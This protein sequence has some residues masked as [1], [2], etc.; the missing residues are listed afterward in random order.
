MV[1]RV[2]KV[3]GGLLGVALL[4]GAGFYGW[5][6]STTNQMRAQVYDVHTVDLP[7]PYPLTESEIADL[8]GRKAAEAVAS[9]TPADGVALASMATADPAQAVDPLAGVDLNAIALENAV[10]RGKHLVEARYGCQICHG[11]DFSGGTMVDSPVLGTLKG[12]NLTGGV[13]SPVVDFKSSD[14]ERLVRH[15]VRPDGTPVAMPSKDYAAMSD[16][17]LSDI[18]AYIKSQPKVDNAVPLP[19]FG[20]LF[21]VLTALGKIR[22]SAQDFGSVTTHL[23]VPPPAGP[24]VEFGEHLSHTC[25]GCHGADYTG[26]AIEGGDPAWPPSA[27]LT[28]ANVGSW[29]YEEFDKAV[30]TGVR[31]DGQPMKMPMTEVLPMLSHTTPDETRALWTFFQTLP[32]KP[33]K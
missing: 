12:L 5:A 19:V 33:T 32:A 17:E 9:A 2:L 14:W 25:T 16:Q 10:A 8:R 30:R 6:V 27:N 18:I 4:G 24:T 22:F 3:V 20:P 13:G 26:G 15:G 31:K 11:G 28:Q 21:N 7:V 1:K 23:A 29:T